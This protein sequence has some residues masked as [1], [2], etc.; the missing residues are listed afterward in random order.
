MR[1]ID[2]SIES[3]SKP[4]WRPVPAW[5]PMPH[6]S[7][8]LGSRNTRSCSNMWLNQAA[9]VVALLMLASDSS[10]NAW[11]GSPSSTRGV[12]R[13]SSSLKPSVPPLADETAS[14]QR[15]NPISRRNAWTQIVVGPAT[16]AGVASLLVGAPAASLAL[17]EE[18]T[19]RST[20]R[21][22]GLLEPFQD[23]PR[24]IRIMAPSGWN[25]FEG[26]VG[27]YDIKWQDLVD[28]SENVKISSTPVKSTT[29]SV[30][31]LG[32]VQD[33]GAT[34]AA[35]RNAKLVKASE[36]LTD[37]VLFY[38]FGFAINDGTHQLL[39]LCVCKGKLWSLDASAKE[40][41]WSKREELYER[42]AGS[43]MPKLA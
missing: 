40:K 20:S 42:I 35:K 5:M 28:P 10:V 16:A 26:E 29:E 2:I 8:F 38:Q 12:S 1:K 18:E 22:G 3:V 37:G 24:G 21:L 11:S 34:L 14:I 27:A 15:N 13:R 41:R 43:F 7:H 31:V 23:G 36:R 6:R 32:D 25:K 4:Q 9:S 17:P 39:Q 30:A 19:P 33:L